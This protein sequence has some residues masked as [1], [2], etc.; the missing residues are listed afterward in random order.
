MSD[1]TVQGSS[2]AL[3][4][5]G[6]LECREIEVPSDL[7]SAAFFILAALICPGSEITLTSVG[8]NPSRNGVLAIFR[9]MGAEITLLNEREIG[10][11]P[12]ADIRVSSSNLQGCEIQGADIAL[13][14]DEIPAIAVAAA[15]ASG[16]TVIRDAAELRVKESDRISSTVRGLSALGV[17]VL[18]TEDGMVIQGGVLDGGEVDS[19]GDHRIAMA[20]AVA[21]AAARSPVVVHNC[22]NVATSFP[23]FTSLAAQAGIDIK[24]SEQE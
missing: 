7:S 23:E 8:N 1:V 18:E 2:V 13:A 21:G 20:F 24:T 9:R 14:I 19:H 15:V 10:G 5:G 11:E 3:F 22:R 4:G 16:E 12:V 6:S 17:D